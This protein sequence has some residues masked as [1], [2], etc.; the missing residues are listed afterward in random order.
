[1]LSLYQNHVKQ[2]RHIDRTVAVKV[3][4]ICLSCSGMKY[5]F[6]LLW[7]PGVRCV[8]VVIGD[9][10]FLLGSS[11]PRWCGLRKAGSGKS[12]LNN[13]ISIFFVVYILFK[14][15]PI[16]LDSFIRRDLDTHWS[17]G[18]IF[19]STVVLTISFFS[20]VNDRRDSII[21]HVND[22]GVYIIIV[23]SGD[24]LHIFITGRIVLP[25][26]GMSTGDNGRY[27]VNHSLYTISRK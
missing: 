1:M 21:Q 4:R 9:S 23:G 11:L 6:C 16:S 25:I 7:V 22:R 15:K 8:S 24:F 19:W 20:I 17:W 27:L 12:I 26:K 3:V 5:L 18:D 13:K 2:I 10:S 14:R